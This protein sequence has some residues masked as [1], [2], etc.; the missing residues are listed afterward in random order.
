MTNTGGAGG[1]ADLAERQVAGGPGFGGGGV[2]GKDRPADVIHPDE[3]Y[4]P[5][6]DHSQRLA[7]QPEIFA[8][9]RTGGLVVFG[10]AVGG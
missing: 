2:G 3:V 8:D 4:K 9:Q 10:D 1:G 6:L 7:T 5:T